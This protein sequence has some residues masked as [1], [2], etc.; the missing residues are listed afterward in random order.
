MYTAPSVAGRCHPLPRH[1]LYSGQGLGVAHQSPQCFKSRKHQPG[2][3]S[4]LI[5]PILRK[6]TKPKLLYVG[7]HAAATGMVCATL[8]VL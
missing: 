1:V 3:E 2:I 4:V 5:R 7:V 6:H 8:C